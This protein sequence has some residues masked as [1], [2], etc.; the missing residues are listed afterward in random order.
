MLFGNK[1]SIPRNEIITNTLIS[2]ERL[3]KLVQYE[4][5]HENNNSISLD[6]RIVTFIEDYLEIGEVNTGFI[7]DNLESLQEN[8]RYYS[9]FSN[10]KFL[11]NIK[12]SL[13]KIN[14]TT[15][16]EVIKLHKN[17]D[18]TYKNQGNYF[19]KL[20]ALEKYKSKRDDINNL[21]KQTE[22]IVATSQP[23]MS[24]VVDPEL[25][26]LVL[27][28][29]YN[30]V[31]QRDYLIE[32]QLQI[33]DYINKIQYQNEIFKK[34]QRLKEL[35]DYE[36]LKYKTNYI[37][38]V[39]GIN[40]LLFSKRIGTKSRLSLDFLYS[41]QGY[42]LAKK[43]GARLKLY[44]TTE[45]KVAGSIHESDEDIHET[46]VNL[47]ITGLVNKFNSSG[48]DLFQFLLKYEFPSEFGAISMER[49]ISLF[50]EISIDFDD[51][52]FIS[53]S[54]KF[55]EIINAE[56]IKQK[57]GYAE[58]IPKDNIVASKK[59]KYKKIKNG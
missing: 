24:A 10:V 35:K 9:E 28:L 12:R 27:E 52:L 58:I 50:V 16:R 33:I 29:R 15:T 53:D 41:D 39:S 22:N 5:I 25:N 48:K 14:S 17:I 42:K 43:V 46:S 37:Q 44:R 6:D 20:L 38:V 1:D 21:I 51:V 23:V 30:M 34:I 40:S 19:I 49:R 3:E 26:S 32:I 47:N 2:I 54:F 57:I 7:N 11:R 45:R 59:I 56:G 8:L 31:K 4:I 13:K 55:T 36:E 18:D